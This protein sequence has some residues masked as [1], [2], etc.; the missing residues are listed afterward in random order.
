[1]YEEKEREV[2]PVANR[3]EPLWLDGFFCLTKGLVRSIGKVECLFFLFMLPLDFAKM[4]IQPVLARV[5][6]KFHLVW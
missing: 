3:F 4:Y 5:C 6:V 2:S 1:M